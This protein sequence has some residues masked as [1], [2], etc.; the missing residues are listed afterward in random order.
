MESFGVRSDDSSSHV[1]LLSDLTNVAIKNQSQ[2]VAELQNILD[3]RQAGTIVFER[4]DGRTFCA[5]CC[6]NGRWR[7]S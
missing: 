6:A 2:I 4:T 7:R 5:S 1:I 3:R